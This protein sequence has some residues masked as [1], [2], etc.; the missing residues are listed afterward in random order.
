MRD[1]RILAAASLALAL[2]A[3]PAIASGDNKA[4]DGTALE[5]DGIDG[6]N[7]WDENAPCPPHGQHGGDGYIHG[8]NGSDGAN[9]VV[10]ICPPEN[11]AQAISKSSATALAATSPSLGLVDAML[12]EFI[13][14]A[15]FE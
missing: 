6:L 7:G 13:A 9:G 14:L 2:T 3:L 1:I 11:L 5:P 12:C 15:V 10:I 4:T 8:A